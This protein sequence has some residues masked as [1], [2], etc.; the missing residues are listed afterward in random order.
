M[1]KRLNIRLSHQ[2]LGIFVSKL[3]IVHV[4][5]EPGRAASARLMGEDGVD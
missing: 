1:I 5:E 2:I 3:N 4:P